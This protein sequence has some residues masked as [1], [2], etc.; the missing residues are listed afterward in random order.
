M[1]NIDNYGESM[2]CWCCC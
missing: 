1:I 2:Y